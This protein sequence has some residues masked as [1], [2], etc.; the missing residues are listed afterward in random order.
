MAWLGPHEIEESLEV[1]KRA[2]SEEDLAEL[3]AARAILPSWIAEPV[4]T[5]VAHG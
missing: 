2:L 3:A 5:L 1:I 4:S